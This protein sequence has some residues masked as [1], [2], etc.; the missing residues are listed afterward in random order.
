MTDCTRT[1][2]VLVV[3]E[4]RAIA[5]G[6][7]EELRDSLNAEALA[8]GVPDVRTAAV[9]V[10]LDYFVLLVERG[11]RDGEEVAEDFADVSGCS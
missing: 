6:G 10:G 5:L 8:E 4:Q 7:S 1:E 3:V 11:G 2:I 9:A